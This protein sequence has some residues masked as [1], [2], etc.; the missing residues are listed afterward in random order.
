[1][2]GLKWIFASLQMGGLGSEDRC[3]IHQTQTFVHFTTGLFDLA[4]RSNVFDGVRV[5]GIFYTERL[6]VTRTSAQSLNAR[7]SDMRGRQLGTY[8]WI[9]VIQGLGTHSQAHP[10]L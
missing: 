10:R 6:F 9:A 5:A 8:F 7:R 4:T 2:G 3:E 1:M